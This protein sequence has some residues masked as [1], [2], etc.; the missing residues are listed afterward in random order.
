MIHQ[1]DLNGIYIQSFN[2]PTELEKELNIKIKGI[3]NAIKLQESYKGFLWVK[4]EK[5]DK[6][7]SHKPKHS[8][9]KIG[10]YTL[11]ENLVKIYNTVRECRKDFPN[12]SKVLNGIANHC[13]NFI[14]KY[15]K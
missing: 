12:V 2:T 8:P 3:N 7:N 9:R 15:L 13:H 14:F 1:Y 4:G 10:Q 6:L 5:L 11:E